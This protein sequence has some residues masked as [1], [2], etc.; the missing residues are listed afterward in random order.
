MYAFKTTRR[1]AGKEKP[2]AWLDHGFTPN[3]IGACSKDVSLRIL[4]CGSPARLG[5][6]H[7]FPARVSSDMVVVLHTVLILLAGINH[8]VLTSLRTFGPSLAMTSLAGLT[9]GL[10]AGRRAAGRNRPS[11]PSPLAILAAVFLNGRYLRALS[12]MLNSVQHLASH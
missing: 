11:R 8:L 9:A 5:E 6:V 2:N 4:T 1:C 7:N 12:V 3:I 10:T